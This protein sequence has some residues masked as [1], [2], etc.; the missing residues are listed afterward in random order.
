M[1]A[2]PEKLNNVAFNVEAID[3][4]ADVSANDAVI[5]NLHS[6]ASRRSFVKRAMDILISGTAIFF[7]FPIMFVIAIAIRMQDG[8][9]V[10]FE[11]ERVG[12]NGKSFKC[13]KFR[14]MVVDAERKLKDVL[15]NDPVAR[16]EWETMRKL[17]VDPRIT[18]VGDFLRKSSLDELPQLFNVIRGDMSLVGPRP[19]VNDEIALYADEYDNYSSMR[20][21]ISGLWQISGRSDVD[22]ESRVQFDKRYNEDWSILFDLEIMLKTIPALLKRTGAR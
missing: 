10:L 11:Q 16:E 3:A 14:S 4:C 20:P 2:L 13:L 6:H 21:G 15:D 8:G 9:K 18:W 12:Y 19:I 22:F 17:S 5:S 7:A 1:S